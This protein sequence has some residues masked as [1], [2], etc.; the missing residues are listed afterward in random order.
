MRTRF[1]PL[2]HRLLIALGLPWFAIGAG[3][4]AVTAGLPTP[5]H[6]EN[7]LFAFL[8][9]A[10]LLAASF[11]LWRRF[12]AW[13]IGRYLGTAGTTAALLAHLLLWLPLW[14]AGCITD[15][16][17]RMS[18]SGAAAGLWVVATA[19]VWWGAGE[20][21]L[22]GSV[23]TMSLNARRLIYS[24]ALIPFIPGLWGV[25]AIAVQQFLD[26]TEWIMAMLAHAACSLVIVAWWLIV[27]RASVFATP[28]SSGLTVLAA[29]LFMTLS[30]CAALLLPIAERSAGALWL[31]TLWMTGPLML[32]GVW[33]AVTPL[34]WPRST[35]DEMLLKLDTATVVV[36]GRCGYSLVGLSATRCPECGHEETLNAFIDRIV[37]MQ[38]DV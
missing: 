33:F 23:R 35:A 19:F 20:A 16:L 4:I 27:W 1:V 37:R 3:V 32:T 13:T 10:A 11:L 17:L 29:L 14:N 2:S 25:V 9:S 34:L 28:R 26:D 38:P 24:F 22:H 7:F 5:I 21:A 36:C 8:C 6:D 18:Q 15:D 31:R 12:I 30:T